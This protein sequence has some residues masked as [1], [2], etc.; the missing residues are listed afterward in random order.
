M[1]GVSAEALLISAL[2]NTSSVGS[3]IIYGISAFDFEGYHDE[4]GWLVNYVETY[5]SQPTRDIFGFKF[6]G[7]VFSEHT[8][9]RSAADAV[10]RGS[11]RRRI[12]TAMSTAMDQLHLGDADAAYQVLMEA[13][14]KRAVIPP[15]PILTD[16]THL[17]IDRP[18]A[19]E[20]PYPSLQRYTGGLAMGNLWYLAA[21]PGQGKSA[22]LASIAKHAML[23]G[24]RV[25]FYSLEM[26]ED[27]VRS[28]FHASLASDL[29]YGTITLDNLRVRRVEVATYERFIGE[30]EDRLTAAGGALDVHTPADGPV[31]PS[32]VA[33]RAS[34]Y[35][36][37]IVDY[38][39]LMGCDG[40]GAAVDDWRMMAKISNGLKSLALSQK[41]ALL[42]A[43]QINRDGETGSAPPKVKNLAQSDSLGQDGDVVLTM[44]A[45]PRNVATAFSLEKNRH[46]VSGIGFHTTFDPN[47]GVFTEI[48]AEHAEDLVLNAEA[49][50]T[51]SPNPPKLRVL[52]SKDEL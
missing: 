26:S 28:R 6:P 40:G 3:E 31:S 17:R 14:P 21:R 50:D 11:N 20:L 30:L 51:Y 35:D 48:S 41:V 37:V 12:N 5:A 32:V 43:A 46:G 22:H 16:R 45:K 49:I 34:E 42:C 2:I 38:V 25:L 13:K 7:F 9:V 8:D 29:G 10:H 44:R 4:Y 47:H 27:E 18:Y 39:G 1:A 19:I 23:A 24:N 33:S 36:L 52:K 15:R